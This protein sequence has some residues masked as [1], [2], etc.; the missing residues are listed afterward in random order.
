[1][2]SLSQLC[3]VSSPMRSN[4]SKGSWGD[5][6]RCVMFM[7]V[8]GVVQPCLEALG[9]GSWARSNPHSGAGAD[10]KAPSREKDKFRPQKP[11][12]LISNPSSAKSSCQDRSCWHVTFL[13]MP[14]EPKSQLMISISGSFRWIFGPV[15]ASLLKSQPSLLVVPH[16]VCGVLV[17]CF[18]LP[19]VSR[20]AIAFP[21]SL[22]LS[23]S[24]LSHT[25]THPH[26]Y[27]CSELSL[28]ILK[29][30]VS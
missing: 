4:N 21:L 15:V 23:Q 3:Q 26:P 12:H 25:H 8:P 11:C 19:S 29:W 1:M 22:S 6:F 20:P 2:S 16:N 14:A 30:N 18:A 17:F 7:C 28:R 10:R 24:A 27:T 13:Y 5:L 9:A